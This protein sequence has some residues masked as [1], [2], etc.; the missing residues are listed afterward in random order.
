MR[1][2]LVVYQWASIGGIERA[3]IETTKAIAALG[4]KVEVWSVRDAGS[5]T[6]E[7]ISARGLA[8]IGRVKGHI[9][10][11]WTWPTTLEREVAASARQFDLVVAGHVHLF[12]SVQRALDGIRAGKPACW[13]WAHGLEVWGRPILPYS[14]SLAC[15][16]RVLGAQRIHGDASACR[17]SAPI[18][19][20]R[21][22]A[23]RHCSL[24]PASEQQEHRSRHRADRRSPL[25]F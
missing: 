8:P 21:A 18:R 7:G 20:R 5:P 13:A 22:L 11:R 19:R 2:L 15:A 1:V 9:H 14:A 25:Q 4:S 24:C 12:P 10:Q 3:M 16:D 23:C 17:G 6:C